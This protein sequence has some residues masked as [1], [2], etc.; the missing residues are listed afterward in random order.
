MNNPFSRLG[1]IGKSGF[2]KGFQANVTKFKKKQEK[3][4]F[5]SVG[6]LFNKVRKENN[7]KNYL[8]F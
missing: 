6:N 2:E 7:L 8:E 1:Q 3:I 5:F 4:E